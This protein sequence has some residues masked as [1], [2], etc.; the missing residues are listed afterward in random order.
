M[1]VGSMLLPGFKLDHGVV[2]A[3]LKGGVLKAELRNLSLYGGSG[4]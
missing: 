4:R 3:A 1:V 2:E